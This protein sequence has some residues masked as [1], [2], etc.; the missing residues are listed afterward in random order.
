M[1]IHQNWKHYTA[2][3]SSPIRV[4]G[5]FFRRSMAANSVDSGQILP[6]FK[7]IQAFMVVLVTC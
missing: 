7:P 3:N 6:N 5:D 4:Y 1:K 2:H